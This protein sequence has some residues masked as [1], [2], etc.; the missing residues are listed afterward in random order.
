MQNPFIVIIIRSRKIG[1]ANMEVDLLNSENL[2]KLFDSIDKDCAQRLAMS[3]V[4]G[5]RK[6]LIQ[7]N[8]ECGIQV[9]RDEAKE[10]KVK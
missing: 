5:R 1:Q 10:K 9:L 6:F 2:K 8:I 4:A 3:A 7:L